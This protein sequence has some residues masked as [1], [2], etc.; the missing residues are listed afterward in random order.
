MRGAHGWYNDSEKGD[1][2]I[3]QIYHRN[4]KRYERPLYPLR[5]SGRYYPE[6]GGGIIFLKKMDF[7]IS[8]LNKEGSSGVMLT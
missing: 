7:N 8:V 1:I 5:Q 4:F 6:E 2:L 3:Y